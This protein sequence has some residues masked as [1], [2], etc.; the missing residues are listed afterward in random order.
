[1]MHKAGKNSKW[2][3]R[4]EYEKSNDSLPDSRG[5]GKDAARTGSCLES[6]SSMILWLRSPWPHTEPRTSNIS[7]KNKDLDRHK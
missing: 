3:A 4:Q 7:N 6:N 5:S 1:M 2:V